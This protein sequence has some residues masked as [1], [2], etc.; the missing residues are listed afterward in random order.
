V[1]KSRLNRKGERE[2]RTDSGPGHT[3]DDSGLKRNEAPQCAT[4]S[5]EAVG[6]DAKGEHPRGTGPGVLERRKERA[7]EPNLLHRGEKHKN[8]SYRDPQTLKWRKLGRVLGDEEKDA[9]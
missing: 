9:G 1:K 8:V 3:G 6:N 7:V 4:V 5:K 2:K